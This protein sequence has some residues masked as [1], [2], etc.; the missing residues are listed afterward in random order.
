M[1]LAIVNCR[2]RKVNFSI[3]AFLL[4]ELPLLLGDWL[5]K[6]ELSR[7]EN[8]IPICK[9]LLHYIQFYQATC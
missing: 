7:Y 1:N 8:A 2:R 9:Q 5:L 3:L 6:M 4:G